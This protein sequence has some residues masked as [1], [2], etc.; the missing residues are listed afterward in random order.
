M[1]IAVP[2]DGMLL[3]VSA[4]SGQVVPSGAPLF[5]VV[6]LDHIWIR[7]AVYVG[8]LSTIDATADARMGNLTGQPGTYT[9]IAK[10]AAAPPSANPTTGTVDL[11]Y[12]LANDHGL[13]PGQRVGVSVP[14]AS[15]AESLVVPWSSV[16][17]DIYGGT[18]VYEATDEREF[19]RRRV[20]VRHVVNATAVLAA[21][22][23]AGKRIV[24]AGAAEL[25]GTETGFSK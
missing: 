22:P 1:D 23:D 16:V 12:G 19:T 3:S 21:G 24:T 10:K 25:F 13:R 18:W 15:S 5:D 9:H 17:H 11:Y 2:Q 20:V 6:N 8:D 7:V 4:V 14:L